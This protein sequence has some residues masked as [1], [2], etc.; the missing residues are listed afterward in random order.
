MD[1]WSAA[2]GWFFIVTEVLFLVWL[3]VFMF[4]PCPRPY[5]RMEKYED[6][7]GSIYENIDYSNWAN[8]C[9]SLLFVLKRV[10][11]PVCIFFLR[12]ELVAIYLVIIMVNLCMIL[13]LKP[14]NDPSMHKIELFN[15]VIGM[16]FFFSLQRFR[17]IWADPE[18][19]SLYAWNSISILGL[20]ITTHISN[21]LIASVKSYIESCKRKAQKK[22]EKKDVMER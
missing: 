4:F 17:I 5:L 13:H 18:E 8:R 11:L 10:I 3:V 16:V 19:A 20:F 14:Y 9:I 21:N 2:I 1:T 12:V 15:E 22:R 6:K 7:V